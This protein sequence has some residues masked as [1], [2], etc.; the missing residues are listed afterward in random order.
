MEYRRNWGRAEVLALLHLEDKRYANALPFFRSIDHEL[1]PALL[2][3]KAEC[4]FG[5]SKF[6]ETLELIR[7]A[8]SKDFLLPEFFVLKGKALFKLEELEAAKQAFE[9]A[10]KLVPSLEVKRW[11]RR[12]DTFLALAAGKCEKIVRMEPPA[13]KADPV[14]HN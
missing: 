9:M 4:L 8:E 6:T 3:A 12:C 7:W 2:I 10:N 14:N 1:E 11:I 5:A 13:P